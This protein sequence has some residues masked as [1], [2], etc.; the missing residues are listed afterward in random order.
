MWAGRIAILKAILSAISIYLLSCLALP[1]R[2][3]HDIGQQ[4]RKFFWQETSD[5]DKVAL[6]SWDKICR[7]KEEGGLGIRNQ[8]LQN[9]ALRA[10]LVWRMSKEPHKK[11]AKILLSKY[12]DGGSPSSILSI[13]NP[14]WVP[15]F[16]TLCKLVN[17]L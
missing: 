17:E 7:P 4:M 1:I 13:A 15:K 3:S 11:R 12:L 6:I 5:K 9:K 2:V 16:E 10:K 8:I 14:P